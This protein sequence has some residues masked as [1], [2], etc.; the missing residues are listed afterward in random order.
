[1]RRRFWFSVIGMI[2][3]TAIVVG[4]NMIADARLA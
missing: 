2:A 1:M 3:V 4:I